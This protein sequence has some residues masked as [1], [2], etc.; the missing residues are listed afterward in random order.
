MV[1]PQDLL[2]TLFMCGSAIKIP[3]LFAL[4]LSTLLC[5]PSRCTTTLQIPQDCK[6][7][8]LGKNSIQNQRNFSHH[9]FIFQS[10]ILHFF[11]FSFFHFNSFLINSL[12]LSS[13]STFVFY[14]QILQTYTSFL[15]FFHSIPFYFCIYI[16]ISF[17]FFSFLG[18]SVF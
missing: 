5:S 16:Y 18:F 13:F 14:I 11:F 2:S 8:T 6:T 4:S 1:F 3:H 15:P 7:P 12:F 10:K 9:S 17:A